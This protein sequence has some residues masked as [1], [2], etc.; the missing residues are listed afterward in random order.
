[1][2]AYSLKLQVIKNEASFDMFFEK[3]D[4]KLRKKKASTHY[5]KGEAPAEFSAKVEDTTANSFIK[6]LITDFSK[7]FR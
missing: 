1:M 6:Y 2:E 5:R 4:P 3:D 7:D